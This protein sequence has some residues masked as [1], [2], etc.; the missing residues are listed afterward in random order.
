VTS[1]WH[2]IGHFVAG[3]VGLLSLIAGCVVFARRFASQGERGWAAYSLATEVVFLAGFVGIASGN[4]VSGATSTAQ[5]TSSGRS[6]TCRRTTARRQRSAPVL[7]AGDR[8]H[9]G[10]AQRGRDRPSADLPDG[11]RRAAASGLGR[12]DQDANNRIQADHGVLRSRLRPVRGRKQDRNA[13][14]GIVGHA[15]VRSV[16]RGHDQL[17]VEEPTSRWV[18]VA[19]AETGA[20]AG[21]PETGSPRFSMRSHNATDLPHR[22][23]QGFRPCQPALQRLRRRPCLTDLVLVARPWCAGRRRCCWT[24]TCPRRAQ[25]P[26]VSAV[27]RAAGSSTMPAGSSSAS[28]APGHG[29][30]RWWPRSAGCVPCRCL[31]AVSR[32]RQQGQGRWRAGVATSGWVQT[33]RCRL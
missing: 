18:A 28:T 31:P 27:A 1:S 26:A 23:C 24:L 2:G 4:Q 10:H 20:H 5:W 6:S 21:G 11:A 8:R 12:T 7:S 30:P 33:R 22:L 9:H 19:F 15:L 25:D 16:R 13:R 17:A 29:Q 14:V 32:L 3:G